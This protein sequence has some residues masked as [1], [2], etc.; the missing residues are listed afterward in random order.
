MPNKSIERDVVYQDTTPKGG[1]K[2]ISDHLP[3]WAEFKINKL[4]QELDHII[5]CGG[6]Q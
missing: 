5:R 6:T 3:L 2:E 4:T 1:N